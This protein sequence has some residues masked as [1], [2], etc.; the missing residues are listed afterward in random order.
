MHISPSLHSFLIV[1][2]NEDTLE[3]LLVYSS[4]RQV[5][6]S[7]LRRISI[8][9]SSGSQISQAERKLGVNTASFRIQYSITAQPIIYKWF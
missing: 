5:P 1:F 6:T 7:M 8:L 2:K 3:A 4:F 9:T